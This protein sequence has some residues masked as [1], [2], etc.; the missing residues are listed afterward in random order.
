[1]IEPKDNLPSDQSFSPPPPPWRQSVHSQSIPPIPPNVYATLHTAF[2][3]GRELLKK[4][5]EIYKSGWKKFTGLLILPFLIG[6][7]PLIVIIILWGIASFITSVNAASPLSPPSLGMITGSIVNIILGLLGILAIIFL[8]IMGIIGFFSQYFLVR[9]LEKGITVKQAFFEGKRHFWS[10]ILI[11][12]LTTLV[13]FAGMMLFVIPGI[14]FS[15]WLSL[16]PFVFVVEGLRGVAALKRSKQIVRGFWWTVIFRGWFFGI[17]TS[18]PVVIVGLIIFLIFGESSAANGISGIIQ[19][20][21]YIIVIPL[22]IV[23]QFFIFKNLQEI[24]QANPA[25]KENIAWWKKA[26]VVLAIG[27]VPLLIVATISIVALG[28]AREKGR[29]TRRLIDIKGIQNGLEFYYLDYEGYP[30]VA[31]PVVLGSDKAARLDVKGWTNSASTGDPV[32]M[33]K[34]PAN[35]NPGG[36]DYIYASTD[37]S[38]APCMQGPTCAAYTIAFKL[39]S[40]AGGYKSGDLIASPPDVITEKDKSASGL[41]NYQYN[42]NVNFG[43]NINN[44]NQN[45]NSSLFQDTDNDGL[46]DGTEKVLGTNLNIADTD[47]D[48]LSDGDEVNAWKTKPTN[49]DTDSD[50]FRD[51]DE[52]KSGYNPL[53]GGKTENN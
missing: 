38:G 28:T 22:S 26:L 43:S 45:I 13:V 52:V 39:E 27:L 23:Y 4:S 10:F 15:I 35:S 40:G 29:D 11:H 1:M 31:S 2:P 8:F 32:Y 36:T 18:L 41:K 16:A 5:W 14:V 30:V 25:A 3:S 12:L 9:D 34:V 19:M 46:S 7:I 42:A 50:G 47:F 37:A 6:L 20:L 17:V 53:G 21:Y 44:G 33:T 48:G 51:G 24:K 49:P